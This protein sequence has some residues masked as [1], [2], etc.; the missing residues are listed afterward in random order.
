MGVKFIRTDTALMVKVPLAA[1]PDLGLP[2]AELSMSLDERAVVAGYVN[3]MPGSSEL[4]RSTE[5]DGGAVIVDREADDRIVGV[6]VLAG[7]GAGWI[8]TK[9]PEFV[10]F[11]RN[12]PDGK[13]AIASVVLVASLWDPL[14]F[15]I[16]QVRSEFLRD[17]RLEEAPLRERARWHAAAP[18]FA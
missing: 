9:L 6:E 11:A 2:E 10:A 7:I 8:R 17:L 16:E 5:F 13:F 3:L 1:A 12:H 15:M 14:Q 18:M 4:R